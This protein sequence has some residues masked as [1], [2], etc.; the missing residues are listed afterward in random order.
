MHIISLISIF[1]NKGRSD[2]K[3]AVFW[4]NY[5]YNCEKL[6]RE[7]LEYL[8]S[9][10][11][12]STLSTP[13]ENVETA[14]ENSDEAADENASEASQNSLI[15][16][17]DKSTISQTVEDDDLDAGADDDDNDDS[18][19]IQVKSF[20]GIVS[21]PCSLKSVESLVLVNKIIS[22]EKTK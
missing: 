21:S 4:T 8:Q 3:E 15:P 10:S 11:L 12:V 5:F 1:V 22:E 14:S 20:K 19:Y 16:V 6:R 13:G 9:L 2:V 18:S 7:H 17:D